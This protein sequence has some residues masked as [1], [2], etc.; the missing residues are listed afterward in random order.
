[1]RIGQEQIQEFYTQGFTVI[2]SVFTQ[3][4]IAHGKGCFERLWKV[5]QGLNSQDTNISLVRILWAKF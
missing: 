4:E 5:A 2:D 1:M 3:E